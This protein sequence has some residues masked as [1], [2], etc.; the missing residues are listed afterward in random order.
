MNDASLLPDGAPASR[1]WLIRSLTEPQHPAR[2]ILIGWAAA[3]I[4]ALFLSWIVAALL[5]GIA[6]PSFPTIDV[7]FAATLVIIAP[8]LE[9][10]I[11]AAVIELLLLIVPPRWAVILSAIGWGIAHSL[12]ALAWGLV[13][14]WVF[15]IFSTLYVTW[16]GSGRALAILIV[17]AVHALNN[18]G[19][20]LLLLRNG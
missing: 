8:F 16:R 10:L 7:R 18:L 20:A 17:F 19:P 13:I 2:A 9:T 3:S 6:G 12:S 4:P 14:W 1:P 5:P 15:L 11:M